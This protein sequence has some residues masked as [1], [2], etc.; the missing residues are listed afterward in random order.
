MDKTNIENKLSALFEQ[1]SGQQPTQISALPVSGSDRRYFRLTQESFSAIGVYNANLKENK[2]FL[3]FTGAFQQVGLKVPKVYSSDLAEEFYLLEDLGDLTLLQA[4]EQARSAEPLSMEFPPQILDYYRDAHHKLVLLQIEGA[5]KINFDY[6]YPTALFNKQSMLWDCNQFKYWYLQ[7]T[8]CLYDELA[9][10]TDFHTLCAYLSK[11]D[12]D[13][14]M[15]RDFQARNIMVHENELYFIDYQGGRKGPLQYDV[16]SLL[17]QAKAQI[18]NALREELLAHYIKAVK[19]YI[20]ID[21]SSFRS[22]YYGFVLIRCMQVLGAY[23]FKGYYQQKAHFLKSIPY[24]LENLKWILKNVQLPIDIDYLYDLLKNVLV[25]HQNPKE[26][27]GQ[28]SSSVQQPLALHIQSFSYHKGALDDVSGHGIGYVFDCRLIHNP[29][30][31]MEYKQLSGL[32]PEV[33]AFFENE[34]EMHDFLEP[35][36]TM[37]TKS[38]NKYLERGF[39]DLGINF[40]CTGGQ[41][42]SVYAAESIARYLENRFGEQVKINLRH[43][44]QNSWSK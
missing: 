35:I 26:V 13:Y 33:K 27:L 8:Q 41:H 34:M 23:G 10:E 28:K 40:G 44:E 31:Y 6:C 30:R 20:D 5:K 16:A 22:F 21:E 36:I 29:G 24:E 3:Q 1:W 38:V 32:D 39:S 42:R 15:F 43:R 2:A 9:L 11:A 25:A 18:P 17:F 12:G 37:L 4:L 14:F 7:P 19:T